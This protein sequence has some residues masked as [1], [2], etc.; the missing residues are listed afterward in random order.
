MLEITQPLTLPFRNSTH[1]ILRQHAF[2][3]KYLHYR[4]ILVTA[5]ITSVY[6]NIFIYVF[7]FVESKQFKHII[8][9]NIL[10]YKI[11][12][13]HTIVQAKWW[14]FFTSDHVAN[15]NG[16]NMVYLNLTTF[17]VWSMTIDGKKQPSSFPWLCW[18]TKGVNSASSPVDAPPSLTRKAL[19]ASAAFACAAKTAG[20]RFAKWEGLG[21]M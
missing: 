16:I 5:N 11:A 17:Y 8:S 2:L 7:M 20:A 6:V 13:R 19:G 4:T 9:I 3:E 21:T 1:N 14:G 10:Q 12:N 18:I 15:T